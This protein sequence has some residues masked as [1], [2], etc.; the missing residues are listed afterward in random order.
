[1][2]LKQK[3]GDRTKRIDFY[4]ISRIFYCINLRMKCFQVDL[5]LLLQTVVFL[6]VSEPVVY[7]TTE[8]K[9]AINCSFISFINY[10][11]NHV[12][13][14]LS[15]S[16]VIGCQ[17]TSRKKRAD[18]CVYINALQ[19]V[20]LSLLHRTDLMCPNSD[21]T[22]IGSVL[23]SC[24]TLHCTYAPNNLKTGAFRILLCSF[25][26]CLYRRNESHSNRLMV[27]W[28]SVLWSKS[29]S[30]SR[31]ICQQQQSQTPLLNVFGNLHQVDVFSTRTCR[32][33]IRT[34]CQFCIK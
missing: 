4:Y 8:T 31:L 14:F 22:P 30:K 28:H 34:T 5:S 18:S 13:I 16:A 21:Q 3:E 7:L 20:I 29:F 26:P 19:A 9:H 1:M 11:Q 23:F 6:L 32:N 33:L 2:Q 27:T 12:H 15:F 17:R 24:W 25:A 10:L